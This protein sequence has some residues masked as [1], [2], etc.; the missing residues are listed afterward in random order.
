MA[1]AAVAAFGSR[2]GE[3]EEEDGE[4]RDAKTM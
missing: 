4:V 3:I 1:G 2:E